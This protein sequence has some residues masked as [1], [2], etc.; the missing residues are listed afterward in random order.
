MKQ[1]LAINHWRPANIIQ[2]NSFRPFQT[3]YKFSLY[4]TEVEL[5]DIIF[6]NNRCLINAPARWC[7]GVRFML[8]FNKSL[9]YGRWLAVSWILNPQFFPLTF[10]KYLHTEPIDMLDSAGYYASCGWESIMFV[11]DIK[12]NVTRKPWFMVICFIQFSSCF[13]YMQQQI[14]KAGCV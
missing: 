13:N 5:S 2:P 1:Y 11:S 6:G 7:P 3:F 8:L 4:K 14:K 12:I 9:K 10:Q